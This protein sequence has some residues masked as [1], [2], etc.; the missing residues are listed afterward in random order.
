MS[1]HRAEW[2]GLLAKLVTPG[3][4][5]KAFRAM[6]SFLPFMADLPDAAFTLRSLEHV[7]MAPRRLHIPDLSEIKGPLNA[8]W[9]DNRPMPTAIAAPAKREPER[10]EISDEERAAVAK[11]IAALADSLAPPEPQRPRPRAHVVPAS[12]L[13]EARERLR[14]GRG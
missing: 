7:A 4:P 8:W 2:L 12:V 13:D 3:D 9:R 5:A 11:Q 10:V 14:A 6:E 1:A